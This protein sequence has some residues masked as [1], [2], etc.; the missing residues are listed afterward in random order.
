MEAGAVDSAD[1]THN[2]I[3]LTAGGRTA[4]EGRGESGAPVARA[5]SVDAGTG[6]LGPDGAY[7][8]GLT[9]QESADGTAPA[10]AVWSTD[11]G[12]RRD[13]AD[14]PRFTD[15]A[16]WLDDE[17]IAVSGGDAPNAD[18]VYVCSVR[19]MLGG[20]SITNSREDAGVNP[21]S[22]DLPSS[23]TAAF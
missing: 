7:Y 15:R 12:N 3:A 20:P 13:F 21:S 9:M 11:T 10:I 1:L 18:A 22:L 23:F 2:M 4:F 5:V 19:S 16:A 6:Q 17:T 8:L 14:L